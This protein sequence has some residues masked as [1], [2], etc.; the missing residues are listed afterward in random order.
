MSIRTLTSRAVLLAA[1]AL[2]AIVPTAALAAPHATLKYDVTVKPGVLQQGTI[3]K[4]SVAVFN[5]QSNVKSW[6]SKA[7]G[8]V[9]RKGVTGG[10]QMPFTSNGFRCTPTVHAQS[11]NYLCSLRGADVPTTVWLAFAVSFR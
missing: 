8:N 3:V 2:A 9:V 11:T 6:G 5:P 1:L 7:A 10:Y 4:T